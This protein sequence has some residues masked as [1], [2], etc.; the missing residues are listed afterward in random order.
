LYSQEWL[1][2]PIEVKMEVVPVQVMQLCQ[3]E[4]QSVAVFIGNSEKCFIINVD[5]GVGRA[6]A[7]SLNGDRSERPQTHELMGH[8]FAAFSIKLE[9]VVINSLR[10]G[11]YYARLILQAENE[12]HK[13]IIEIDARPSDCLALALAAK[14]PVYVAREVW[15]E[16][17]D[18]SGIL[19]KMIEERKQKKRRSDRKPKDGEPD[20]LE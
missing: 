12:V 8:I 5:A 6:I 15:D 10:G 17:D 18:M 11:T 4:S 16:V 3:T 1:A 20:P 9:R 2:K 14:A 13:K 19:E 7:M